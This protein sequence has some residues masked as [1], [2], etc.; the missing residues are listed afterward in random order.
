MK[1][2]IS[3]AIFS[4]MLRLQVIATV[5]V[6]VGALFYGLHAGVSGF[7]GGGAVI[8]ASFFATKIANRE[9]NSPSGALM[10]ILKA[11]VLKIFIIIVVLFLAFKFYTEILPPALLAGVA[12]AALI[13]GV[14]IGRLNKADIQI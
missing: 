5:V 3:I 12:A 14:A 6:T 4:N 11:E 1:N 9:T 8:L 2:P 10:N 13:S 7:I